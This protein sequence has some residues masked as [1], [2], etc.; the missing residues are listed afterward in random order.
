MGKSYILA[1]R[2]AETAGDAFK[3]LYVLAVCRALAG[4][5]V[6]SR[7]VCDACAE[8]LRRGRKN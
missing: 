8:R 6:I 4:S 5:G 7:H 1:E 2:P 3:R